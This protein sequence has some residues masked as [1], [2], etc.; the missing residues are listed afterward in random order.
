MRE[1]EMHD[2]Q[3]AV[4]RPLLAN[5]LHSFSVRLE[6]APIFCRREYHRHHSVLTPV[7]L[8]V[9][10][11][12]DFLHRPCSLNLGSSNT[13]TFLFSSSSTPSRAPYSSPK[14]LFNPSTI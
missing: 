7:F 9:R 1:K 13:T 8:N 6:I 2:I 3:M 10:C 5:L 11:S 12:L 14:T 4:S